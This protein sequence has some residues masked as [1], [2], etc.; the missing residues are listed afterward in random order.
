MEN[1]FLKNNLLA[2]WLDQRLSKEEA[3][4]IEQSGELEGLKTVIDEID[5]WYV[6]DFDVEKGLEDLHYRKYLQNKKSKIIPLVTRK[7]LGVAASLL[8]IITCGYFSWNIFSNTKTINQ[9]QIAETKTLELPLGSIVKLDALT[10]IEY[11]QKKWKNQRELFLEGQ[12][13]FKVTKGQFKI[14]T[15]KGEISVL[16]TQFN[17]NTNG[18]KFEVVCY[19]GKVK[20]TN[21]Q[22]SVILTQGERVYLYQEALQTNTHNLVAPQWVQGYSVFNKKP[23]IEVLAE[24]EERF[25]VTINLPKTYHSLYYT[26]TLSHQSVEKALQTLCKSMEL[27]YSKQ[28][29]NRYSID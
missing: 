6:K 18:E 14:I 28:N 4:A 20:V 23:L 1:K 16:G 15:S 11:H 5:H 19:E 17:V 29:E 9:T 26:G 3:Y 10:R 22:K 21:H 2:R 27:Q 13:F 8:V 12:A 7:W 24:I 25:A